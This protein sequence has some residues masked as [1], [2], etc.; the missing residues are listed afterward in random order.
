MT[1]AIAVLALFAGTTA[2]AWPAS[3]QSNLAAE[4]DASGP[5][6]ALE[7]LLS[8]SARSALNGPEGRSLFTGEMAEFSQSTI[9][10]IPPPDRIVVLTGGRAVARF[11]ARSE[12]S[13]DGYLYLT[14]GTDGRWRVS[15]NRALALMGV[16]YELRRQLRALPERDEEQQWTLANLELTLASDE[17]LRAWFGENRAALERL[18]GIAEVARPAAADAETRVDHEEARV[19]VRS[20]H[21]LMVNVSGRGVVRVTLGGIL[22]NEVGVLHAPSPADAPPI[23]PGAYIWVEPLGDGWYLYKTT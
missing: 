17:R 16:P 6:A 9:G 11:P 15:A 1:R 18:R 21:A 3:A 20:L 13:P 5:R 2:L 19:A 7:Q 22:D 12:T 14:L 23:S 10:A 4:Q 8:L